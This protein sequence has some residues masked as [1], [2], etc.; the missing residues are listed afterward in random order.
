MAYPFQPVK[1]KRR[2]IVRI[3][4]KVPVPGNKA[5]PMVIAIC[6]YQPL[7]RKVLKDSRIRI[8]KP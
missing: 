8:I 4:P 6:P 1:K 5:I 3:K 2:K 7:K